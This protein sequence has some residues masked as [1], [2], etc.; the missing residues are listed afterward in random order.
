MR[1]VLWLLA[2]AGV[3][4]LGA[5][6]GGGCGGGDPA[7]RTG[8]SSVA[9]ATST[10]SAAPAPAP[11]TAGAPPPAAPGDLNGLLLTAAD[12]PS[13]WQPTTLDLEL[14]STQ[15]C[16]RPIPFATEATNRV[17]AAFRADRLGPYVEHTVA[18]YAAGG[19]AGAVEGTRALLN[20]CRE[21]KEQ[22]RGRELTFRVSPS[23]LPV[24]GLGDEA[25]AFRIHIEGLAGS[26]LLGDALSAAADLFVAR[27]GDA[28]FLLAQA[29]GGVGNP[30]PDAVQSERLT[31]RA[32]ALLTAVGP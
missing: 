21:W 26:G 14:D 3:L 27:R 20:G 1:L 15:P 24:A 5:C 28:A 11:A 23:P 10:Q 16:G 18:T 31:Q 2:G 8:G 9:T 4:L 17:Q 13:G 32:A 22:Y 19:G 30:T 12:L 7:G 29:V 6:S 25:F